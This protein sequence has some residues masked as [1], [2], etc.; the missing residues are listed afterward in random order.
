MHTAKP[1]AAQYWATLHPAELH[2]ILFLSSAVPSELHCTLWAMLHPTELRLLSIEL[3]TLVSYT[4]PCWSMMQPAEHTISHP[5]ELC[6]TLLNYA[7]PS[8]QCCILLGHGALYWATLHPIELKCTLL[9]YTA[10]PC[11]LTHPYWAT[12]HL[13]ELR[14]ALLSYAEH[15]WVTLFSTELHYCLTELTSVLVPLCNFVK[16]RTVRYRNKCTPVRYRSIQVPDWDARWLNADAQ[17][18]SMKHTNFKFVPKAASEFLLG[19]LSYH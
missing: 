11:E 8:E 17:L 4:A 6:C 18:C 12:L 15:Y 1:Y 16:C 2:C 13:T 19:F 3:H 5:T 10:T 7:A 9:S 14:W